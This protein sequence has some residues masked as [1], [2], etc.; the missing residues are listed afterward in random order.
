MP[1]A[2]L[3]DI[4]QELCDKILDLFLL[5]EAGRSLHACVPKYKWSLSSL[6]FYTFTMLV[7]L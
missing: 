5:L 1:R 7:M 6:L 4:E 3:E 2:S